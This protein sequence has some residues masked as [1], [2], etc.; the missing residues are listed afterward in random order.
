MI[1][2]INVVGARP[3]FMKIGPIIKEMRRRPDSIEPL[4]VHTGQHYD[5]AMSDAFFE[6]LDIPRADINLGV[7][8][9]SHAEQTARIMIAFEKVLSDYRPDWVVVVG[10]VNSTMAATLVASKMLIRVAHVEAG[11]RSRDRTM[12]EEINRVVTDALADL[13]LTPSRDA[14]ENLE[15]EGIPAE[16]ICFVG[17][18]MIDSLF[19][20]LE[21]ARRSDILERLGLEAGQFSAMTL[22]RPS[23][24]D[25]KDAL[26]GILNA[27]EDIQHS[28]PI[29]FPIHPRTRARLDEF[30]LMGRVSSMPNLLLTSPLG[31]LD[32]LQLYSNSRLVL[33]DSGGIQEE[34]TALGI[35]CLTLRQNTERPI[36]VSEG[37]NCV[38]G[39]DP[40]AIK[41]EAA[42]ALA[43]PMPKGR[44]PELWDGRAAERI[45]DAIEKAS[46]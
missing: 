44:V 30:G 36:T 33:T 32:F 15:A 10:D 46:R 7:G 12:P 5:E 22:H 45:V 20:N 18:V 42:A 16:R 41:R 25:Y 13:L 35:P 8:S 14:N 37:T 31:Y 6:D 34:T 3:N 40:V 27:L 43:R 4:L 1:R 29:V 17:N 28:I 9:A 23:N 19:D 38:V 2:I 11:L 26:G 24:V 39:N 21:R